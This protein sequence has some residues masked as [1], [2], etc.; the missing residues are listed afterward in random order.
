MD[1]GAKFYHASENMTFWVFNPVE[2]SKASNDTEHGRSSVNQDQD[3][4]VDKEIVLIQEAWN[5]INTINPFNIRTKLDLAI[6][7]QSNMHSKA[8]VFWYRIYQMFERADSS[9]R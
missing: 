6:Q 7:I 2:K 5:V 1:N 9:I 4:I 3:I 8:T